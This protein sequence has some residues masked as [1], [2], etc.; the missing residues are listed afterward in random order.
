MAIPARHA[1]TGIYFVTS[2]TSNRRRR[3]QVPAN[4]ELF[5][6]TLQHYRREDNYK[7]HAFV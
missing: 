5:I 6:E 3:F 2:I 1:G 4:A 7:L